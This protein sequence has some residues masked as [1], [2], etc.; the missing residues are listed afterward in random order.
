MIGEREG[1][2]GVQLGLLGWFFV[3][4]GEELFELVAHL[5]LVTLLFSFFRPP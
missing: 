5:G 3:F 1:V 2:V 4:V